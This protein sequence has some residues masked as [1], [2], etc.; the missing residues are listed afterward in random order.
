MSSNWDSG[1]WDS[2]S[3]ASD[4]ETASSARDS[5]SSA[6]GSQTSGWESET[7]GWESDDF[8]YSGSSLLKPPSPAPLYAAAGASG[9]GLVIGA[10]LLTAGRPPTTMGAGL[11]LLGWIM[12]GI[13]AVLLVTVYQ[14]QELRASASSYYKPPPGAAFRRTLPL[15]LGA[16]GVVLNSLFFAYWLATR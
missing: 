10:L 12:S 7:S 3:F 1:G 6:W 5:G 4:A 14:S 13:V 16:V 11:A 9:A 15:L 2:G 8:V